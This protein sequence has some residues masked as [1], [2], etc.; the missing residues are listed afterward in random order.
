[1]VLASG[2]AGRHVL[3]PDAV[4]LVLEVVRRARHAKLGGNGADGCDE[5]RIDVHN[6]FADVDEDGPV[7]A[8]QRTGGL[9]DGVHGL[10]VA[11]DA[12]LW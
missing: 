5:G 6:R 8:A 4:G 2:A 7:G 9:G 10:I 11:P 1:M 3:T 12:G